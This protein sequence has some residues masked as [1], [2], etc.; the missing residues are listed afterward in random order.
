LHFYTNNVVL[1]V[2]RSE[3]ALV[4]LYD[5]LRNE[6]RDGWSG[7]PIEGASGSK[8]T[9]VVIDNNTLRRRHW[10]GLQPEELGRFGIYRIWRIDRRKLENRA[11]K[12][13]NEGIN[14]NWENNRPERL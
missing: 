12:L 10:M 5:R 8:T 4:N 2:G 3:Y 13:I 9:L 11:T 1:Y 6:N 7:L 14:P